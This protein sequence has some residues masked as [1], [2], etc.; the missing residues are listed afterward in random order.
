MGDDEYVKRSD[1]QADW[2]DQKADKPMMGEP[3]RP[4]TMDDKVPMP[5][6]PQ[7][8]EPPQPPP[9]AEDLG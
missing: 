6:E 9:S 3:A 4:M 8:D 7:A 2:M 1:Y 5:P